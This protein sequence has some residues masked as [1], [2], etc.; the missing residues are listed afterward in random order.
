MPRK[1]WCVIFNP[2]AGKARA[3]KRLAAIEAR[4][5]DRADFLPTDRAGHAIEL[6]K[7]AAL[8]GYDTVI[9]AGGDGTVHEVA[10]GILLANRPETRFAVV[11]VG[12]ANDYAYSLTH[13]MPASGRVDVGLVRDPTGREKFFLCNL[14]LGLNGMVTWESRQIRWLQ[15]IALYGLATVLALWRHYQTPVMEITFD[16]APTQAMPTLMLSLL[17]G[18][19][20]GGFVMAKNA[21]LDDG[22]FDY[23]QATKLSRLEVMGFLPRLAFFGPPAKHDKVRQGQCR[24]LRLRS[25]GALSIH[26]DGEFFA[27]PADAVTEIEVEMKPAALAVAAIDV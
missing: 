13:G 24:R 23:V 6:A 9:A 20:E 1:P 17:V 7:Q 14:G 26:I 19:R 2:S 8:D 16:D 11:P 22:L 27:T 21:K 3:G 4:L 25:P 10:N 15:G 12:S 18:H 5:R